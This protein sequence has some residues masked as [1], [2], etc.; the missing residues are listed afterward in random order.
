MEKTLKELEQ[1]ELASKQQADAQFEE[2]K[3]K[4]AERKRKLEKRRQ[5]DRRRTQEIIANVSSMNTNL[6]LQLPQ[7]SPS[8]ATPTIAASVSQSVGSL[9]ETD[10]SA[11]KNPS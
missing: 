7:L 4:D 1:K 2:E 9:V 6:N 5:D 10:S 11:P 8:S 3:K